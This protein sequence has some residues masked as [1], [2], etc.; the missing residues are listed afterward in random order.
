MTKRSTTS[1][2]LNLKNDFRWRL[3]RLAGGSS[4]LGHPAGSRAW[5]IKSDLEALLYMKRMGIY[6]AVWKELG[7]Q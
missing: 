2:T 5:E 7:F 4:L 1:Y 6:R 3:A